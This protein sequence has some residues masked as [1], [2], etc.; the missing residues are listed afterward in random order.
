MLNHFSR[1]A[2]KPDK[3]PASAYGLFSKLMLQ[4]KD[5]NSYD[6]EP[7]N[8]MKEVAT[9]WKELPEEQKKAYAEEVQ[10]VSS[11][12]FSFDK[13]SNMVFCYLLFCFKC[14]SN[15]NI[16]FKLSHIICNNGLKLG[17]FGI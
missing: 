13:C 4:N 1:I 5:D 2:G 12:I 17:P 3:P 9:K 6:G 10:H 7:K 11:F 8:R 15:P 14:Q 16:V